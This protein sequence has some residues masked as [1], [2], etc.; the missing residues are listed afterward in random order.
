MLKIKKPFI[1]SIILLSVLLII[2]ACGRKGE[3]NPNIKPRVE[4]TSYA[5]VDSLNEISDTTFFQ[6]K[7]YWTGYDEDG[8]VDAYAFR[9][10]DENGNPIST[11]GYEYIDADGW[12]YHYQPGADETIPMDDPNAK[13]TIWTDQVYA[14]INFPANINGELANVVSAFEVKCV[15]N[16]GMESD[17]SRKYLF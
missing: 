11:P 14:E 8:V 4:I 16:R 5:G 7:I 10:L 1:F 6:Q 15:D 2:N 13:I 9:I 3:L 12:V 17:I